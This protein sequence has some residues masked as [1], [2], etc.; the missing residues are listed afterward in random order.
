MLK[1][2]WLALQPN[3]TAPGLITAWSPAASKKDYNILSRTSLASPHVTGIVAVNS[4]HF[5]DKV[6]SKPLNKEIVQASYE[7]RKVLL[8]SDLVKTS[9]EERSLLKNLGQLAWEDYLLG[10]CLNSNLNTKLDLW[11]SL[12]Y[13]ISD[14]LGRETALCDT[15][16]AL[17]DAAQKTY[18]DM[19]KTRGEKLIR[20]TPLVSVDLFP[21]PALREGVSILLEIIEIHDSMMIPASAM[22]PD[23]DPGIS[24]LVDPK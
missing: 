15:V 10:R 18:F 22:K 23:F 19:L 6:N 16:W 11:S 8:G 13:T 21:L 12:S 24:A 2:D 4:D 20:Y 14:L 9:S 7:K 5:L 1:C 3:V 17:K